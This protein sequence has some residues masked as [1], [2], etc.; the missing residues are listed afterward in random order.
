MKTILG[1]PITGSA[2]YDAAKNHFGGWPQALEAAGFDPNKIKAYAEWDADKVVKCIQALDGKIPLNID[3]ILNETPERLS[4][5]LKPILGKDSNGRALRMAAQRYYGGWPQALE[6]AGVDPKSVRKSAQ[7]TRELVV[8][9]IKTLEPEE[10]HPDLLRLEG[11]TELRERL[12]QVTGFLNAGVDLHQAGVHHFG[13]WEAALWAAGIDPSTVNKRV[14]WEPNSLVSFAKYLVANRLPLGPAAILATD[15]PEIKAELVARF[16][17]K[18]TLARFVQAASVIF[19]GWANYLKAAGIDESEV[20]LLSRWDGQAVVRAIQDLKQEGVPLDERQISQDTSSETRDLLQRSLGR[21]ASGREL[22]LVSTVL[23]ENWE[24]AVRFAT[25]P[26]AKLTRDQVGKAIRALEA[27][28]ISTDMS[29]MKAGSDTGDAAIEN[30]IGVKVTMPDL[31]LAG[32]VLFGSWRVAR[33][34]QG[35]KVAEMKGDDENTRSDRSR[36]IVLI[37]HLHASGANL[38]RIEEWGPKERSLLEDFFGK[39]IVPSTLHLTCRAIFGSWEA[40]LRAAE[41]NPR[42]ILIRYRWSRAD[43]LAALLHLSHSATSIEKSSI[44]VDESIGTA[45]EISSILN[46]RESGHTLYL[47]AVDYFGSWEAALTAIGLSTTGR[48]RVSLPEDKMRDALQALAENHVALSELDLVTDETETTQA[49]LASSVGRRLTGGQLYHALRSHYTESW[50]NILVKNELNLSRVKKDILASGRFGPSLTV[51]RKKSI[52]RT[53]ATQLS[54][55]EIIKAI[56][57]LHAL[58]IPIYA[59]AIKTDNSEKTRSTLEEVL[60]INLS[61]RRLHQSIKPA[62]ETWDEALAAAGIN[63]RQLPMPGR[64]NKAKVTAALE[65][66]SNNNVGLSASEMMA[67]KDTAVLGLIEPIFGKSLK[68][69]SSLYSGAVTQ[70]GSWDNAL[71]SANIEPGSV[72]KKFARRANLSM[73]PYQTEG[74]GS[75]EDFRYQ[76]YIG[77]PPEAP[78]RGL[79]VNAFHDLVDEALKGIEDEKEREVARALI[80]SILASPESVEPEFMAEVIS[81]ELGREVTPEEVQASLQ[82]LAEQPALHALRS[83][84]FDDEE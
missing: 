72:K 3:H 70:F 65:I 26:G 35:V 63:T 67:L 78:D 33:R 34:L 1:K 69:G 2:L 22:Y 54:R 74:T 77:T 39:A 16:G 68:S 11:S 55:D 28:E 62:F 47:A 84:V 49:V 13:S 41:L 59:S 64:W 75:D 81:A 48:A 82:K 43:V 10:L 51:H 38:G 56:T 42:D 50:E 20:R 73:L 8:E 45:T 37:K 14:N 83:A 57:A 23:F 25:N 17:E 29:S 19:K 7:W 30:A 9:A 27:I 36:L 53:A 52:T 58:E 44:Q 15:K 24:N 4:P 21:R 40:A 66:L 79:E 76:R 32:A 71:R 46:R 6:A 60:Q 61:G 18:A 5:F 80:E 12:R 31:Y